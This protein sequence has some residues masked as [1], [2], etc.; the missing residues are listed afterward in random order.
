M[1]AQRHTKSDYGHA[2]ASENEY[3]LTQYGYYGCGEILQ[4]S[5]DEHFA[6]QLCNI[7]EEARQ[8]AMR[9][10][11][12]SEKETKFKNNYGKWWYA[13]TRARKND[14]QHLHV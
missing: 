14:P 4:V 2:I 1:A 5:K 13:D 9:F 6:D 8:R 12:T 11:E 10:W 3:K 7:L